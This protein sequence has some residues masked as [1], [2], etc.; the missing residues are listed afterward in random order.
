MI[1]NRTENS[2]RNQHKITDSVLVM[3][4]PE[5]INLVPVLTH[6][7][8][9]YQITYT[10]YCGYTFTIT[11]IFSSS[12]FFGFL[13][14]FFIYWIWFFFLFLDIFLPGTESE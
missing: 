1:E 11:C 2:I 8:S 4:T 10:Q 14:I 3:P 9:G 5:T 12:I 6:T 7:R 13:D